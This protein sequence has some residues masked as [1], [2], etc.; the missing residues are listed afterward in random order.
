VWLPR[1][2]LAAGLWIPIQSA[3]IQDA[4]R[5]G[6]RSL[7]L[8]KTLAI[9]ALGGSIGPVLAGWLAGIDISAPYFV[10]GL[11]AAPGPDLTGPGSCP[12]A[13]PTRRA[14]TGAVE[15]AGERRIGAYNVESV[16]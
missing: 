10:S 5:E 2:L 15:A 3:I 4:C 13:G 14:R 8:S 11:L 9:P 6:S 7:D 1:D 16:W 12:G